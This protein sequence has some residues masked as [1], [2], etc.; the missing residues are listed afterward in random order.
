MESCTTS[1]V[2]VGVKNVKSRIE[3]GI[4]G[5][6]HSDRK[7]YVTVCTDFLGHSFSCTIFRVSEDF[8]LTLIVLMWIIG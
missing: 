8:E 3:K 4:F 2:R 7:R 1:V 6:G 5:V